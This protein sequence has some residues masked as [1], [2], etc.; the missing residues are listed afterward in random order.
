MVEFALTCRHGW[1]LCTFR[2]PCTW[3]SKTITCGGTVEW[4]LS[5]SGGTSDGIVGRVKRHIWRESQFSQVATLVTT[6]LG[7]Q[8][9]TCGCPGDSTVGRAIRHVWRYSCESAIP[10]GGPV[11]ARLGE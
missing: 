4:K 8:S 2:Y 9:N 10:G 7:E 6:R 1:D 5:Q 11:T 3:K